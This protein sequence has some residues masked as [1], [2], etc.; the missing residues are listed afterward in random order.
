M[1][2]AAAITNIGMFEAEMS[3]DAY[4]ISGMADRGILPK[5]LGVRNKYGTPTFGVFLSASGVICLGWMSFTEVV[6][7]LNLLYCYGQVIEF[8][9]FLQLRYAQPHMHRPYKIC[10]GLYGMCLLLLFPLLFIAVILCISSA[11]ALLVSATLA[12]SGGGFYYLLETAKSKKW[13]EFENR[14]DI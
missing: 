13:C 11:T 4:Q 7:M 10:I 3:S 5:V 8:M 2:F 1:M 6:D 12:L 14:E 9:A